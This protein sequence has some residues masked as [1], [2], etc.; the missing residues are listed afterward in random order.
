MGGVQGSPTFRGQRGKEEPERKED[1]WEGTGPWELWERAVEGRA[2]E[3][4]LEALV[5]LQ[6]G[7]ASGPSGS[8][9]A[10]RG[11]LLSANRHIVVTAN[12]P[13]TT[14]LPCP[15]G[16]PLGQQP[17]TSLVDPGSS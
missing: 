8:S 10:G 1:S 14:L 7:P 15:P 11:R 2:G 13:Q 9:Q 4:P 6:K 5:S 12:S 17:L 3:P 16:F